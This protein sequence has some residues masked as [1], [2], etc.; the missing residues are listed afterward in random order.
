[1]CNCNFLKYQLCFGLLPRADESDDCEHIERELKENSVKIWWRVFQRGEWII[2]Y[3][4][5]ILKSTMLSLHFRPRHEAGP[6]FWVCM[7]DV[8][9][10]NCITWSE[11]K[12]DLSGHTPTYNEFKHSNT[13]TWTS[14]M[15][16]NTLLLY[17]FTH[18]HTSADSWKI[19]GCVLW[20]R[21]RTLERQGEA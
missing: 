5:H 3:C 20:V 10:P 15:T 6:S 18:T 1:M 9:K 4:R 7:C 16:T 14:K 13:Y 11:K 2:Y 8:N 17:Q 21:E 19:Q 12:C